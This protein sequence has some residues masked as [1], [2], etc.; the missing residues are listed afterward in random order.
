MHTAFEINES[1]FSVMSRGEALGRDALLDWKPDDRLGVIVRRPLGMLEAGLLTL[2]CVTAFYD[3]PGRK[4]RNRPLYPSIY[5]FHFGG[6]FGF[7]GEFDFWPERKEVFIPDDADALLQALND[8]GITHLAVPERAPSQP[9]YRYKEPEEA[10]DRIRQCYI[11]GIDGPAADDDVLI[12]TTSPEVLRNFAH[13][14]D[15]PSTLALRECELAAESSARS[16]GAAGIDSR[17]YVALMRERLSEVDATDPAAASTLARM[18]QGLVEGSLS[19][20][21]RRIDAKAALRL[22]A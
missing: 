2:L 18:R 5:L 10:V 11:Y 15:L 4:R 16:D 9:L 22:L 1:M 8:R 7:S 13:T 19:E 14:I 20:R 6:R 21:L 12:R 17:R 3:V